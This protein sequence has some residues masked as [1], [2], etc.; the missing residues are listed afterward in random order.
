MIETCL[1][2]G[3]V[4]KASTGDDSEACPQCGAVYSKVELAMAAKRTPQARELGKNFWT[5]AVLSGLL[6]VLVEQWAYHLAGLKT[7]YVYLTDGIVRS[8]QVSE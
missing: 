8:F 3:H 7:N 5:Y 6:L 2:C 1:K 4:N